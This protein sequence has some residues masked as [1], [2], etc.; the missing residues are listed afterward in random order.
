MAL[1]SLNVTTNYHVSRYGDSVTDPYPIPRIVFTNH[2][3]I[4]I[5][6]ISRSCYKDITQHAL[7]NVYTYIKSNYKLL[8]YA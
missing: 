6:R 4:G 5:V 8:V 1:P 2:N 7:P 3:T